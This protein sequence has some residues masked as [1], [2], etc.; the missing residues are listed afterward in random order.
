MVIFVMEVLLLI[1]AGNYLE[2]E[3]LEMND[4]VQSPRFRERTEKELETIRHPK[5]YER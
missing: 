2:A 5:W 1:H 3:W 4:D